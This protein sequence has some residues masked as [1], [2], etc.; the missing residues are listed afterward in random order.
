MVTLSKVKEVFKDGAFRM[1]KV[2]QFGA[3][4]VAECSPYGFDSNPLLND[5][6][7]VFAETSVSGEPIIIGFIQKNRFAGVGEVRLYSED[8]N[9]KTQAFMWLRNNGNLE[10]NGRTDN[11]V[12]FKPLNV[13][14]I[15]LSSDINTELIKISAALSSLGGVYTISPIDMDISASKT[16]TITTK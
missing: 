16:E 3:K 2:F 9:G 7:A 10:L 11:L 14:S 13:A 1:F 12:K 5:M 4:T 6:D 15:K 8:E